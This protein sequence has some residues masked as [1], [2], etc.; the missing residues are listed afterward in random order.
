MT[1]RVLVVCTANVCRSPMAEGL[2]RHHLATIG[3]DVAVTSAGT[4]GPGHPPLSVDRHAVT[5][6]AE[7]GVE[8]A[9][10]QPRRLTR[11]LIDGAGAD[12]IITMTRGHLRDV[13]TTVR[14]AFARTFTLRELA[15]RAGTARRSLP[16]GLGA[17]DVSELSGWV[18]GLGF[19]RRPADLL[20]DEPSD[21]IA[22]PYGLS[23]ADV[24]LT[25]TDLDRL[26]RS[27][28]AMSPW[29]RLARLESAPERPANA[30][31]D[32]PPDATPEATRAPL[33][34]S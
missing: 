4:R 33:G 25:A 15:R 18:L 13:A 8:I 20:G 27:I 11:E 34:D 29:P 31:P 22:D 23:L 32:A 30:P 17:A 7:F 9:G 6:L 3:A 26:T 19:G 10:H 16:T 12:L 2:L 5:A 21:D 14:T 24:R 1:A 28:A